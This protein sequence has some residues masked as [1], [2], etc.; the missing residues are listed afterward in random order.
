MLKRP[1]IYSSVVLLA[2][3]IA[4]ANS[5]CGELASGANLKPTVKYRPS[6]TEAA[7]GSSAATPQ[8]ATETAASEGVGTLRGKVVYNGTFTPLPALFEKGADIR[9]A[10]V[11]AA[12]AT[13]NETVEVKNGGLANTFIYLR[14]AP[15]VAAGAPAEASVVFDQKGCVF[16]PHAMIV[17]VG[18]TVKVLNSDSIAHNTHTYPKKNSPFNKAVSGNDADGVPLVYKQAE[19]DPISVVCD[20]HTWMK[21]YHLP[22]DHPFAAVSG[23]DGTFE[24]KDLPAG[25][26]ELKVWHE[27]A[28][29]AG[30]LLEKALVVTIKPGDNELT[31][32]VSPT[33][34]GR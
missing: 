24:I 3:A 21:A 12:T 19:Q 29:P 23:E 33:Q 1:K 8:G 32:N 22:I 7:A 26:H 6:T 18:Q 11:C 17:R 31:I 9:D 28:G 30:G 2:A 34:L 25:K 15:K 4:L 13:P 10:A 14:K 20:V 16:K 27:S 5:G